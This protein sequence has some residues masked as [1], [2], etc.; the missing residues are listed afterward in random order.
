MRHKL[1]LIGLIL[2]VLGLLYLLVR[3]DNRNLD[4]NHKVTV[5]EIV[6]INGDSKSP[7]YRIKFRFLAGE[8]RFNGSQQLHCGTG[9]CLNGYRALLIGK[10]LP[11]VYEAGK[12]QNNDIL[13]DAEMFSDYNVPVTKEYTEIIRAIDSIEANGR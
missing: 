10:K 13:A 3:R 4:L 12:P 9:S 11:V 2:C 8:E 7:T 6:A 1:L 5:G